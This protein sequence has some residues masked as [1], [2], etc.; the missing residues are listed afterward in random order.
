M[1]DGVTESTESSFA[2]TVP[3]LEQDDASIQQ[4]CL[5]HAQKPTA[6]HRAGRGWFEEGRGGGRAGRIG[7][8]GLDLVHM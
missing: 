8:R 2:H 3:P 4:H 7:E 6:G 1:A 5:V